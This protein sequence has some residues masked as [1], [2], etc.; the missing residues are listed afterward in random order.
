M[1]GYDLKE[2]A[3][4]VRAGASLFARGLATGTSGNVSRRLAA[5]QVLI[6]PT[7]VSLGSLA[8]DGLA[9]IDAEGNH[10]AG[11][12]PSKEWPLHLA[13][14]RARPAAAAIVH[15]HATHSAAVSCMDG[16]DPQDC[17]PPLTAYQ[18]MK[19]GRLPMTG[20]Y[21]P[22]DPGLA[23][24]IEALARAHPA[25]L[26]ANH[27]PLVA[28]TDMQDALARIEE[29]EET[30]HLFLMLRGSRTRELTRSQITELE[31]HFGSANRAEES[32]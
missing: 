19:F 27:G 20:W 3:E 32:R 29:L 7:N 26:L 30:A 8:A 12:A 23:P 31:D 21:R 25:I 15:L 28:G 16:L 24:E 14:Y 6:S 22:G 9:L 11:A 10:L 18:V 2:A 4:I 17:L 13:M 5:G 1:P